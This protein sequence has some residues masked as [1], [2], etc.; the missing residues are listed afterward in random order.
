MVYYGEE[1]GMVDADISHEATM[2]PWGGNCGPINYVNCSRDPARTP[3]QWNSA[4][5]AGFSQT[6]SA[7]WLPVN[8]NYKEINLDSQEMENYGHWFNMKKLLSLRKN[9]SSSYPA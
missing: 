5:N 1:I 2:D 7:T 9:V 8:E 4:K 6:D 3:M